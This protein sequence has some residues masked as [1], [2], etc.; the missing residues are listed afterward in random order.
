VSRVWRLI[1][2]GVGA[3][4]L[5][6]VTTFPAARVSGML[7]DQDADLSLNRGALAIQ[8]VCTVAGTD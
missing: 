4:L 8:A 3:Y 1:A 5:I 2:L 6:L 7:L